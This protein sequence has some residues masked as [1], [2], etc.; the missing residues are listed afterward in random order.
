MNLK[1]SSILMTA[2]ILTASLTACAGPE[3]NTVTLAS[4][5]ASAVST[6]EAETVAE[7]SAVT[8][9]E[10]KY[11]KF[12]EMNFTMKGKTYTL[13]KTT[14][15]ELVNDGAIPKEMLD[16]ADIVGSG[17][18]IPIKMKIDPKWSV[19][20][21]AFNPT[22]KRAKK[23]D[24]VVNSISWKDKEGIE[25]TAFNFEFPFDITPEEWEK[26]EG[27]PSDGNYIRV[28]EGKYNADIY[29][30]S[31]R[32]ETYFYNRMYELEFKNGKLNKVKMQYIP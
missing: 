11:V 32:S 25:Q 23:I 14:L 29:R 21:T 10:K 28:E 1:A 17:I 4:A 9:S 30:Y 8:P 3:R 2:L 19:E 26:T 27:R 5:E 13:G 22:D 15:K 7:T 18:T 16:K 20:I 24:C 31:E 6:T 12:D